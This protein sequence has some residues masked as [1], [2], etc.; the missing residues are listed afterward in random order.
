[1]I[2]NALKKR[3]PQLTYV[4]DFRD[5]WINFYLKE[6]A[7]QNSDYTRRRALKIEKDTVELA[8]LVVAVT[9]SSLG[10]IRKRN[11]DQPNRKF[12]C[13]SN[14]FDPEVFKDCRPRYNREKKL[15]VTHV[16]TVYKPASSQYYLDALD[17]LPE[18]I[19]SGIESRFI[20]RI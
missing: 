2:G 9:E 14:G 7:F 17:E 11:P 5:E 12:R 20:G 15:I 10:E 18:E 3:F 19:R 13:I 16:G 8:D 1:L 6:F 4:A